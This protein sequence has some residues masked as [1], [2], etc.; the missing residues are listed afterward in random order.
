MSKPSVR[1]GIA[2][3]RSDGK[4]LVGTR[5][6]GQELEGFS[7][8]PGGKCFEGESPESCV[9]RECKEETGLSIKPISE[10]EFVKHEYDHAKVELHFW[11]CDLVH[12]AETKTPE[13]NFQWVSLDELSN[14]KFPDANASVVSKL[15]H[16]DD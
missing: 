6:E 15:I 13:G 9:V 1:V 7:E 12:G 2:I 16:L 10:L 3:V 14:L 5:T 8:F 11:M 4:F